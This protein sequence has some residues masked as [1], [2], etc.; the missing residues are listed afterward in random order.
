M[1]KVAVDVVELQRLRDAAMLIGRRLEAEEQCD[2]ALRVAELAKFKM[3]LVVHRQRFIHHYPCR[4]I[5]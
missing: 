4:S 3:D 1:S 2:P 5:A